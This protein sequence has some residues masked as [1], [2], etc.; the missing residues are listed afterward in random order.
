MLT[1]SFEFEFLQATLRLYITCLE[2]LF[3]TENE[4]CTLL[5]RYLHL[6]SEG[7]LTEIERGVLELLMKRM[8]SP[9]MLARLIYR[10]SGR[11]LSVKPDELY[12]SLLLIAK[13]STMVRFGRINVNKDAEYG[14]VGDA[15]LNMLS[16]LSNMSLTSKAENLIKL[17]KEVANGSNIEDLAGQVIDQFTLLCNNCSEILQ[18]AITL[19]IKRTTGSTLDPEV[20]KVLLA[21]PV[22]ALLPMTCSSLTVLAETIGALL[23][24]DNCANFTDSMQSILSLLHALLA[25]LS[26]EQIHGTEVII[27][28]KD[29]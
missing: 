23:Y 22:G 26:T 2:V 5:T 8:S 14:G 25:T 11:A 12:R 24:R 17:S 15:A 18:A 9:T 21:S 13:S 10:D 28:V 19:N 1:L 29:C 7:K 4:R 3:P 20:E 27:V 6:L 16:M